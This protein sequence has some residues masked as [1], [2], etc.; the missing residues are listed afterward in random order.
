[1]FVNNDTY[2]EHLF[3]IFLFIWNTKFGHFKPSKEDG[4]I[5]VVRPNM[6]GYFS[7]TSR[8]PYSH[9]NKI[10]RNLFP[11]NI[12][13]LHLVSRFER[14]WAS[15]GT[16]SISAILRSSRMRRDVTKLSNLYFEA[17]GV[18]QCSLRR[19]TRP[20]LVYWR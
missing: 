2:L 10:P 12:I 13:L 17:F 16:S 1:M 18:D 5:Y 6:P 8:T 3:K 9:V 11:T 7:R 4:C 19:F 20:L 15:P 14:P